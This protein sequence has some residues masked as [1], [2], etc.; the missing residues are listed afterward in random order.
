VVT[1]KP[2]VSARPAREGCLRLS[3][4]SV[5]Y[6][7][8]QS[9]RGARPYPGLDDGIFFDRTDYL[10]ADHQETGPGVLSA[11]DSSH[12]LPE[13]AGMHHFSLD[14]PRG[15]LTAHVRRLADTSGV[16]PLEAILSCLRQGLL[17]EATLL[18][19]CPNSRLVALAAIGAAAE[20]RAPLLFAATLNQIDRDGGYTGWTQEAFMS[21][22]EEE[23]GGGLLDVPVFVCLDHGGP[24]MKDAHA[25]DG[26]SYAATLGEVKASIEHCLA[27]GY[28]LLHIDATLSGPTGGSVLPVETVVDRATELIVHAEN[29]R[30]AEGLPAVAYEVGTEEVHGGLGDAAAVERFLHLLKERLSSHG[31]LHAWPVFVVANVG[32]SLTHGHFDLSAARDLD[33]RV[34][35]LGTLLKGHYTDFADR[36]QDYPAAGMGGANLGPELAREE[37]DALLALCR[38]EQ[39]EGHDSGFY[40]AL[41]EAVVQSDRWRKWLA[42]PEAGLEFCHL[43]PERQDWLIG[44]GCRYVWTDPEVVA[45]RQALYGNAMPGGGAEVYIIE[46][47]RNRILLYMADFRITGLFD[48]LAR[49]NPARMRSDASACSGHPGP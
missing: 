14:S 6:N 22:V 26:L 39:R 21:L 36:P 15:P 5:P 27:A 41:R 44:T 4:R 42:K 38:L 28:A 30:V 9:C 19:V 25:A 23:V 13:T 17:G 2:P 40:P 48:R 16:S 10:P 47:I 11:G 7:A 43:P 1:V 49:I 29:F 46:R 33:R 32:T 37:L 18:A 24:W 35:P 8:T 12:R 45:T 20:A 34:R 3:A 31:L